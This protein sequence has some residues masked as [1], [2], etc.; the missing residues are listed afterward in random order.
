MITIRNIVASQRSKAALTLDPG[1]GGSVT[2]N[3]QSGWRDSNPRPLRPELY[4]LG[5]WR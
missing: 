2:S 1:Q 5:V 4:F 3:T